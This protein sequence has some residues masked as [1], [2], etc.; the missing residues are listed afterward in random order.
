MK[1]LRPADD[2][3]KKAKIDM[4]NVGGE[5]LYHVD[6]ELSPVAE[7]V[8]EDE[9]GDEDESDVEEINGPE[10]LR[11]NGEHEPEEDPEEWIDRVADEM[12]EKRRQRNQLLNKK[13]V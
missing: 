4:V 5:D 11:R 8:D 2:S 12:E 10:C 13:C 1:K 7:E 9:W 3:S 6:E